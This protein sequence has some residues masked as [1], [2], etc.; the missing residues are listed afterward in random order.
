MKVIEVSDISYKVKNKIIIDNMS[1]IV[2]EGN[3]FALLGENGSG[4]S[5]LIDI[6][7]DDINANSG[8]VNFFEKKHTIFSNIGVVYDHLP[9]YPQLKVHEIIRYLSTIYKLEY[10][11]VKKNYFEVFS[12][13]NIKDNFIK[14]LSQG[15]RKRIGLL[16]SIINHPSLLILDEPFSN[17]DPIIYDKIWKVLKQENRTIFLTTHNWKEIEKIATNVGFIYKGKLIGNIKSPF[18]MINSLPFNKKI[19]LTKS[20]DLINGLENFSYFENKDG[21][22]IYFDKTKN[23]INVI[24]KYTS[25]FTVQ[26]VDLKD[27]YLYYTSKIKKITL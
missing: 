5:T 6:M 18:K 26:D 19:I 27:A 14:D 12:I 1:F 15:E 17:L 22:Y 23:V 4:K 13:N 9:L 11:K 24:S 20:I 8:Y 10:S 3:I 21:L 25:N 2:D 16:L 7:L